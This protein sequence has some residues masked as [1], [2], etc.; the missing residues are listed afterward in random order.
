MW[1]FCDCWRCFSAVF[2][3]FDFPYF[4]RRG[5]PQNP[6]EA[7]PGARSCRKCDFGVFLGRFLWSFGR[8]LGM[9]FGSWAPFGSPGAEKGQPFSSLFEEPLFDLLLDGQSTLLFDK[10]TFTRV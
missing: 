3:C 7:P 10:Y 8:L 1:H 9:L 5:V 4:G 6:H 2:F